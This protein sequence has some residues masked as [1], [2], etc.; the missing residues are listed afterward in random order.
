VDQHALHERV[1]F[2]RLKTRLAGG[3]LPS[4]HLLTPIVVELDES[5]AAR[6]ADRADALRA[7]GLVVEAFGPGS[8]A[9]QGVPQATRMADPE[10]LLQAVVALLRENDSG[11]DL[12]SICDS[13]CDLIA[14][15][16]AV[17]A[18]DHLPREQLEALLN[19]ARALEHGHTC[20]HGRP[21]TLKVTRDQ[22][23]RYFKRK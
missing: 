13:L 5:D 20:P 6:V 23:E 8:V 9:I 19:D 22:L 17:K 10:R 16:A 4:Q 15:K 1:L 11:S 2:D 12:D 3:P 7:V 18:G 14:C 21:T